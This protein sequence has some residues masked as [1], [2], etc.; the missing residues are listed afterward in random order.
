M[1]NFHFK[2]RDLFSGPHLLGV[3]LILAGI[4][5]LVSPTFLVVGSSTERV[6]LVGLGAF[7]I[8]L[9]ILFSYSGTTIDFTQ[10]K[11]K[12]YVSVGGYKLGQWSP[13]PTI[14]SIHVIVRSAVTSNTP[15]GIYRF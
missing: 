1:K 5:A 2:K 8:G 11:Y 6:L 10:N 7:I 13:L 12:E 3:L 4:F 15:N 9:F 14:S